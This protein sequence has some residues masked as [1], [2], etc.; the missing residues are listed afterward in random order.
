MDADEPK[1]AEAAPEE[2]IRGRD[3]LMELFAAQAAHARV[4]Q[5]AQLA[6]MHPV[7]GDLVSENEA[8]KSR[9]AELEAS[10]TTKRR[11]KE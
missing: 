9:I 8:L 4:Q 5:L 11:T 1:A 3:E 10:Q 6:R 2:N 7:V